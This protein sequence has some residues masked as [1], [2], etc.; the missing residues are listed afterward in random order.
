MRSRISVGSRR[1][2]ERLEQSFAV[3]R[4]IAL[5]PALLSC[6]DWEAIALP[7]QQQ[8]SA[9]SEEDPNG[10]EIARSVSSAM[11]QPKTKFTV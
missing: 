9:E 2:L 8:L 3:G 7:M 10:N 4:P 1:K 5:W 11:R 6:N